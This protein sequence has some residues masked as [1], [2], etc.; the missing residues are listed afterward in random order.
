VSLLGVNLTS[1][2]SVLS[3]YEL[4]Y[5]LLFFFIKSKFALTNKR[6]LAKIPNFIF[7][8]PFGSNDVTYPLNGIVNVKLSTKLRFFR[9]LI[10][11][12]LALI[13]ISNLNYILLLLVGAFLILMSYEVIIVIQ[14]SAGSGLLVYPV[15]WFD[16]VNAQKL[17]NELNQAIA[18]RL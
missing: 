5:S 10:G 11:V 2:E 18:E 17:V 13:G 9:L 6:F 1:E 3:E 8:F 16:K 7:L 12:V 14:T 4:A 15:S